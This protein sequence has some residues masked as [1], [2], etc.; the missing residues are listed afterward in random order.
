MAQAVLL[1]LPE[2]VIQSFQEKAQERGA[3]TESLMVEALTA[4]AQDGWE[5]GDITEEERRLHTQEMLDRTD[6]WGP[7]DEMWD[8]W[9]PSNLA[10]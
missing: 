1:N 8:T 6:L 4:L 5:T 3:P 2:Y 9:Q 7:E 10:T